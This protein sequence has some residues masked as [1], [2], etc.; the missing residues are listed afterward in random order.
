[1]ADAVG[2]L[3][4]F[5]LTPHQCLVTLLAVEGL[6]WLS[7]RLGWP[8][9]H[10]GYAVLAALAAVAATMLLMLLWF[11]DAMLFRRRFQFGIHSLLVLTAAVALACGWLSW[12]R[13][14]AREQQDAVAAIRKA[15][16]MCV[17]DY[18]CD[19]RGFWVPG[20][21]GGPTWFWL[22][23]WFGND[24]LSDVVGVE[25]EGGPALPRV[26]FDFYVT[27]GRKVRDQDLLH[28]KAFPRLRNLDLESTS[29]TDSG[30][31]CI[32]ELGGLERLR[33]S[34]TNLGDKDMVRIASLS[35]LRELDISHTNV[36]R[37]GLVFLQDLPS[38]EVIMVD[39]RAVDE[40]SLVECKQLKEIHFVWSIDDWRG[41]RIRSTQDV[42][43]QHNKVIAQRQSRFKHAIPGCRVIDE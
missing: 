9:W 43:A 30:V 34:C 11:A 18:E 8:S 38:L 13:T 2:K 1:M 37:W 17:Y 39:E 36:S 20:C 7:N 32:A 14:K 41:T 23:P 29:I 10:R 26:P 4:W 3:R 33:L 24:F 25:P 12:E 40:Q 31:A 28:L 21:W 15:G 16:L 6:L 27:S 19:A 22:Q 35:N 5:R 42:V